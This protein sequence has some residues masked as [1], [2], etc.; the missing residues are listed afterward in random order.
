MGPNYRHTSDLTVHVGHKL[1]DVLHS[2]GVWRRVHAMVSCQASFMTHNSWMAW[3]RCLPALWLSSAW[4][5]LGIWFRSSSCDPCGRLHRSLWPLSALWSYHLILCHFV[6]KSTSVHA[7][8]VL[9]SW[10]DHHTSST[11]S[12]CREEVFREKYH[13][14]PRAWYKADLVRASDWVK[15]FSTCSAS[16][17]TVYAHLGRQPALGKLPIS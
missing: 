2:C 10:K 1:W 13:T 4:L 6:E 7:C 5:S 3:S 8:K 9:Q 15:M 11:E 17:L 14:V 12:S 16:S